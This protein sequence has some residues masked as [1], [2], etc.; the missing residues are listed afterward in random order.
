[1]KRHAGL[2]IFFGF[3]FFQ[4]LFGSISVSMG[5][6]L[7][8]SLLLSGLFTMVLG[9]YL[10]RDFLT[11]AWQDLKQQTSIRRLI[12][13]SLGLFFLNAILRTILVTVFSNWVDLE[14][15]G[16]N[17]Q[18]LEEIQRSIHPLIFTF[19]TAIAAPFNEEMVFRQAMN[20]WTSL[21]N[22]QTQLIM[23]VLSTLL[24]TALH[25]TMPQ[26]YLIY[27]PLAI[28][29][30]W[31]YRRYNNNVWASIIF[32]FINNAITVALMYLVAA[33]PQELLE[34]ASAFIINRFK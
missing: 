31:L 26:D 5:L 10:Y 30:F 7:G 6:G 27:L 11:F 33:L 34:A 13:L 18:Y 32:H 17:Q 14:T 2:K 23:A 1:M 21:K 8:L 9:I 29:M 4:L 12:L 15:I 16:E 3:F 22:K 19:A 24:F 25:V 28:T 20:G